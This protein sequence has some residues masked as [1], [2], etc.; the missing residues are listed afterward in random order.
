[1]VMT[2]T[3][4]RLQPWLLQHY[5]GAIDSNGGIRM[6]SIDTKATPQTY[7][8]PNQQLLPTLIQVL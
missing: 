4:N 2:P 6:V 8:H 3:E 1:M 7:K 5:D